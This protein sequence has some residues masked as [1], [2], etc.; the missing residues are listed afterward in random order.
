VFKSV[1]NSDTKLSCVGWITRQI[2]SHH[3]EYSEFIPHLLVHLYNSQL[4]NYCHRQYHNYF[5]C[6]RQF[7]DPHRVTPDHKLTSHTHIF[8][9]LESLQFTRYNST[10]IS[11]LTTLV[12]LVTLMNTPHYV[13]SAL[14]TQK[15]VTC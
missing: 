11:I 15:T 3:I 14:T 10:R 9:L 5:H 8:L 4:H 13:A 12:T 6:S 2:T 7:H 1:N